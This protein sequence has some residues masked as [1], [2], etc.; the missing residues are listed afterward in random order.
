MN[1]TIRLTH[2]DGEHSEVSYHSDS[3]IHEVLERVLGLLIS[4]GWCEE[5][6]ES[7]ICEKAYMLDMYENQGE[8]L[9]EL[10]EKQ[11]EQQTDDYVVVNDKTG[12]RVGLHNNIR[13]AY[14]QL[15]VL[16][17]DNNNTAIQN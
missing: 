13:S 4:S 17:E 7:A 10:Y 5:T 14:R 11:G 15:R 8:T 3:D 9:K 16:N 2:S 12:E 1:N 6:V